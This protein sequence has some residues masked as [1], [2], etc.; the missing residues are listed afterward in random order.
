M[1]KMTPKCLDAGIYLQLTP[2]RKDNGKRLGAAVVKDNF[3]STHRNEKRRCAW[4][5]LL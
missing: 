2:V 1:E 4:V 3:Y 5:P